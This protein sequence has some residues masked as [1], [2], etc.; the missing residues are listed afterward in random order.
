MEAELNRLGLFELKELFLWRRNNI[1]VDFELG[2]ALLGGGGCFARGLEGA[3]LEEARVAQVVDPADLQL[4][5]VVLLE[6]VDL[7]S[8]VLVAQHE[9]VLSDL[10]RVEHDR[11]LKQGRRA[12]LS[13]G[14]QFLLLEI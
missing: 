4:A 3:D 8:C 12:V 11:T 2:P 13:A 9:Q 6:L 5:Q 10:V 1:Q 7:L 14:L